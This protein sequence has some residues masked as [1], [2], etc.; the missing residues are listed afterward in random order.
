MIVKLRELLYRDKYDETENKR[1]YQSLVDVGYRLYCDK[2]Q[3]LIKK[4]KEIQKKGNNKDIHN[5]KVDVAQ[6]YITNMIHNDFS[7]LD[8]V[9]QEYNGYLKDNGDI[10]RDVG[11]MMKKK[12]KVSIVHEILKNREVQGKSRKRMK[13]TEDEDDMLLEVKSKNGTWQEAAE[14]LLN[15]GFHRT[16]KD[17]YDRYRNIEKRQ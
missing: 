3:E 12:K 9:V 4:T 1:R 11:V 6:E 13:W 5:I 17:S 16:P 15:K 2:Y 10:D 14:K 8:E 7:K